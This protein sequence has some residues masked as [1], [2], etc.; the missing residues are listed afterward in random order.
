MTHFHKSLTIS[1]KML[2]CGLF[3]AVMQP[4]DNA[5]LAQVTSSAQSINDETQRLNNPSQTLQPSDYFH[6]GAQQFIYN[7]LDK[8]IQTVEEGLRNY[9]ND[10]KLQELY[11]RLLEQQEQQNNQENSQENQDSKNQEGENDQQDSNEQQ[12]QEE[13]QQEENSENQESESEEDQ[14]ENSNPESGQ[15]ENE[16]NDSESEGQPSPEELKDLSKEEAQKILQALAQKEKELLKEFK[17]AKTT[18]SKTHE[19]DW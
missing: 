18:G 17:K 11:D 12:N 15:E 14:E 4:H 7:Q 3:L 1:Y 2:L 6:E 10:S 5:V 19:K 8:A 9:P 13:N 16:P